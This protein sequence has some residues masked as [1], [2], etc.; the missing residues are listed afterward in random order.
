MFI[1]DIFINEIMNPWVL[2]IN[3]W[4]L[5]IGVTCTL[6]PP[7]DKHRRD[8]GKVESKVLLLWYPVTDVFV[9]KQFKDCRLLLTSREM[10]VFFTENW[11]S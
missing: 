4:L 1:I 8:K 7:T 2:V 11:N 6:S 9:V 3:L 10:E 5:V